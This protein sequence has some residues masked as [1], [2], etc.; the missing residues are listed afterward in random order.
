MNMAPQIFTTYCVY[1][2]ISQYF[3]SSW[4]LDTYRRFIPVFLTDHLKF[5]Q[6]GCEVTQQTSSGLSTG[7]LWGLS[8]GVCW[9]TRCQ[10]GTCLEVTAV[11]SWLFPLGYC[12]A[13]RFTV[14]PVYGLVSS[15]WILCSG[16]VFL[17]GP[18]YI[19][20]HLFLLQVYQFPC[21]CH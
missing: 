13:E 2:I 15:E 9:I 21:T 1:C 12:C 18:V 5:H 14:T 7:V 6:I 17:L 11:L 19:W 10:S 20:L 8:L 3:D 4:K 16:A